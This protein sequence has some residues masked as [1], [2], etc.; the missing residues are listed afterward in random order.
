M[1]YGLVLITFFFLHVVFAEE[2]ITIT[3]YYPS[4]QGVYNT[5]KTKRLAVGPTYFNQKW[6]NQG[7][8]I[9]DDVNLTVE[10]KMGIGT[11]TPSCQLHVFSNTTQGAVTISGA[12][13]SG[14]TYSALYLSDHNGTDP[15]GWAI[16]YKNYTGNFKER[17]LHFASRSSGSFKTALSID[18]TTGNV[19]I[20]TENPQVKVDVNGTINST[21]WP[22]LNYADC[23]Y[24]NVAAGNVGEHTRF[25]PEGYIMVGQHTDG[26]DYFVEDIV[27]C[28][29][30]G[31]RIENWTSKPCY[32]ACWDG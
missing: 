13:D 9:P 31:V 5:L 1:R 16:A 22:V 26:N 21:N 19:G 28:R 17:D 14:L 11:L 15:D 3:T 18:Y 8:V 2:N 30:Q 7:G 25:C 24:R 20:G 12:S 23:H 4:P 6:A 27:C 32:G 10:G 29:L